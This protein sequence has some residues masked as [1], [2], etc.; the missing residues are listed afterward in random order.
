VQIHICE[1][2]IPCNEIAKAVFEMTP[3]ANKQ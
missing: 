1:D 3:S 2:K